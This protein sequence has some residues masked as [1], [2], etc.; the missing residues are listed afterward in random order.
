[1]NTFTQKR[2]HKHTQWQLS[3]SH[4]PEV[5]PC[6]WLDIK[7]Q[8]LNKLL[9]LPVSLFFKTKMAGL[10]YPNHSGFIDF[11]FACECFYIW[12]AISQIQSPPEV[13]FLDPY[14]VLLTPMTFH[15]SSE[16]L[17]VFSLMTQQSTVL[18]LTWKTHTIRVTTGESTI[19]QNA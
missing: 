5:T 6:N 12:C 8:L 14:S 10:L 17:M 15:Y 1:M 2:M 13:L 11:R 7:I 16:L 19:F 4:W 9:L 3:P 18:A